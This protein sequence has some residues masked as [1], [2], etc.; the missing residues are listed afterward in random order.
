MQEEQLLIDGN[1][2]FHF[3]EDHISIELSGKK[4][5]RR[6]SMVHPVNPTLRKLFYWTRKTFPALTKWTRTWKCKWEVLIVDNLDVKAG[7]FRNRQDAI[8]WEVEW[9]KKH[10]L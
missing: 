4:T 1:G 3:L 2:N 5:I 9:L 7:P 10:A 8:D 6:A